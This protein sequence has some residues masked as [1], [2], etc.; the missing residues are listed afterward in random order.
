MSSIYCLLNI[1]CYLCENRPVTASHT[2]GAPCPIRSCSNLP[3]RRK[4]KISLA[5]MLART[6]SGPFGRRWWGDEGE[7][8]CAVTMRQL[9]GSRDST[10][11]TQNTAHMQAASRCSIEA[12]KRTAVRI[13][14]DGSHIPSALPALRCVCD[15]P[16]RKLAAGVGWLHCMR[17]GRIW[18]WWPCL[19]QKYMCRYRCR[20]EV[21]LRLSASAT[22]NTIA[23][24]AHRSIGY[25]RPCHAMRAGKFLCLF[26]ACIWSSLS[27]DRGY[28][29]S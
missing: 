8:A 12:Q 10:R 16:A 19:L 17:G 14:Y 3:L 15:Q 29:L 27:I 28:C 23:S 6:S 25:F 24:V 11:G 22:P 20:Q 4:L 5:T 21:P 26:H 2:G 7:R 13:A 18:I 1:Y 9:A